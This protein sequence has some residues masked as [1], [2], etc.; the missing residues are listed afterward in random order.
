MA[1]EAKEAA[2]TAYLLAAKQ[3][4]F[5]E[6]RVAL[7]ALA[8]LDKDGLER[9]KLADAF[10]AR[11]DEHWQ[12]GDVA[13]ARPFY[14][15]TAELDSLDTE[16]L[17]RAKAPVPAAK[18]PPPVAAAA[19][20]KKPAAPAPEELKAAP[21]DPK[22]SRAA[23]DRGRGALNRLDLREAETSFNLALEADPTNAAAIG[24]LAEV[25]FERSRYA[26][27]LDYARRAVQQSPRSGRYLLLVGD[28][29]FKLL[30]Y[31]DAKAAYQRAAQIPSH[32]AE[33]RG[34]LERLRTKLR[35]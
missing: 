13:G 14:Q 20:A 30:R 31:A 9:A 22:G 2:A 11:A 6:A 29:Y 3:E 16:A 32:Q 25:A 17:A 5:S 35:E 4:K 34:R 12:K 21:R 15:L 24:G 1:D 26:E 27:A 28:A 10:R 19:T 23:V 33:A 8:N 18:E 7:R